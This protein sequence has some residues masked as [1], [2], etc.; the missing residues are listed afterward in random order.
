MKAEGE[1]RF[2]NNFLDN[3]NNDNLLVETP[4]EP[5]NN[6]RPKPVMSPDGIKGEFQEKLRYRVTQASV[7]LLGI[8]IYTSIFN[9]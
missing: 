8:I 6:Q 4:I 9:P 7:E 3:K 5:S 1:T 2:L